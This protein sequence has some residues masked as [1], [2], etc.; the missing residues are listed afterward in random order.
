MFNSVAHRLVFAVATSALALPAQ[1]ECTSAIP[2]QLGAT[3]G[4]TQGATTSPVTG[5][6]GAPMANDVWCSY[7]APADQTVRVATCPGTGGG[8]AF[9]TCL[10]VFSGS[11]G[12]LVELACNDDACGVNS[13]LRFRAAAGTTYYIAVGGSRGGFGLFFLALDA[14]PPPPSNDDC[15]DALPISEGITSG[16]TVGAFVGQP[17]PSCA[18]AG[19]DVW[20]TYPAPNDGLISATMCRSGTGA[21]FDAV[22][23]VFEGGC[24]APREIA[25]SDDACG[26]LPQVTF[27]VVAGMDYLIGVGS[28]NLQQG[29]FALELATVRPANDDCVDAQSITTGTTTGTNRSATVGGITGSC[30]SMGSDVWYVIT[31]TEDGKLTVST[32]ASG[33]Y[34]TFPVVLAAFSGGCSALTELACSGSSELSFSVLAGRPY[35]LA[36]GGVFGAQ[37]NFALSVELQVGTQWA[38]GG[39]R[40]LPLR[41]GSRYEGDVVAADLD[42]D[43]QQDLLFV[44]LDRNR[45]YWNTGNATFVEASTSPQPPAREVSLS[46]VA[47]DVDG[48]G[49]QDL[50]FGNVSQ[51]SMFINDGLGVFT[52]ETSA[53]LPV[54]M[55]R[56][57]AIAC[58]DADGDGDTDLAFADRNARTR[59]YLNNGYG[60][61]TNVSAARI[62]GERQVG[63]FIEAGDVDG[64]GDPDLLQ[65]WLALAQRGHA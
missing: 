17:A 53:R 51:D 62:T 16:S 7:T 29:T 37:G 22:L 23:A 46:A 49:D 45:L 19:G 40:H 41:G 57:T 42:G 31:P 30:S 50:V 26:A 21:T 56:T 63:E 2:I 13:D 35:R 24:V 10:A 43:G 47:A 61:F 8:V 11:C 59:L 54:D 65:V 55:G 44:D 33:G 18:G 9:D 15:A 52:D 34:A 27:A 25:C 5:S 20:Y 32:S 38:E 14:L 58:L 6:C 48:D 60:F 3:F 36:V 28:A 1:D 12:G 64:D 39:K 4:S